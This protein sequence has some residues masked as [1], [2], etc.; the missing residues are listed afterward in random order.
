MKLLAMQLGFITTN[1]K[2][3]QL[4]F[5]LPVCEK[6]T[7]KCKCKDF[8]VLATMAYRGSRGIAPL[9]L[10]LQKTWM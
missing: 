8:P 10:N 6:R 1:I 2:A 7:V 3:H 5:K 9:I 4:V